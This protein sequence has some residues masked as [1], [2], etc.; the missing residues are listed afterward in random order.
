MFQERAAAASL[1]RG[2]FGQICF[3]SQNDKG[4]AEEKKADTQ[5]KSRLFVP[6]KERQALAAPTFPPPSD[7]Q[8][9]SMSIEQS[10]W[11]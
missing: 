5:I 3:T 8:I 1:A 10:F 2:R 7:S 9:I 6:P 4:R 11:L